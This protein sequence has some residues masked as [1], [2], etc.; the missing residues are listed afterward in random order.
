MNDSDIE[1]HIEELILHGFAPGDG[2]R[3]K[4]VVETELTRLFAEQGVPSSL[5]QAGDVTRLDCGS[6][7]VAP[8]ASAV[9]IGTQVA[10]SLYGGFG[11]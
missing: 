1:L 7:E 3:I 5:R 4:A 8:D 10:K 6:F 9:T 2:R 11:R